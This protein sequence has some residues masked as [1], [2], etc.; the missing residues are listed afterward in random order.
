MDEK[1]LF[2]MALGLSDPWYIERIEF[3]PEK[4]RLDLFLEFK[5]GARFL[6][7]ECGSGE[8]CRFMTP[9][10]GRG[11]IS[12]FSSTKRTS[13][14]RFPGLPVPRTAFTRS[15]CPGREPAAASRFC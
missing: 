14:R 13:R 8:P 1:Q 2:A 15:T 7:P 3:N 6:C 11:V 9:R 4:R 5:K 12:I 10:N